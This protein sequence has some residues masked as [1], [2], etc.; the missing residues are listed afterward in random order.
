MT[1]LRSL[2]LALL[3]AAPVAAQQV[4]P[5]NPLAQPLLDRAGHV[6]EDA[7]IRIPLRPDDGR[8]ATIDGAQLKSILME[9]D[10]ISVA[11]RDRGT[12]FWGRNVGT[13]GHV[14]TEDWVAR[15]FRAAG[16]QD[17]HKQDFPLNPQWRLSGW[18]ITF[19]ARG[20]TFGLASARPPERAA[21]TPEGGLEYEL[22]W[23]GQGSEADYIGRDVTGKA[24]LVQDV[25]EPGT[26][27]HTLANED[28]VQRAYEKGAAAVG[29]VFGISDNFAVW[30][31]T[32]DGPGFN[33]GYEDGMRLRDLLGQG[34]RVTV[35]L[36]VDSEMVPDLTAASVWGTLPGQTDEEILI[37]AH[38]DGYFEA[39]LDNASGLAVMMGLLDH[40]S[41]LP[42]SQRPRTIRFLGSVGHHSGP[43]T[44]WL[45]DHA[46]TDL[47]NT[48]LAI[49]LEHVAVVRTQ[50][51]GPRLRQ[52]DAVSPMRWWLYASPAVLDV[53]RDAF[54]R[55]NV[56]ITADMDPGASGEMGRMARDIPSLQVITSPEIKH[57]EQDTPDWVPAVGLEQIARAYAKIIDGVN[58]LDRSQIQPAAAQ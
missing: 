23:V 41:S 49:N 34:E 11:D 15:R 28:V 25:P 16:L 32:G 51:W 56:G 7:Y 3:L 27:N 54:E 47:A 58:E 12:L 17:V 48:A 6:R 1:T 38:M 24:V 33:V 13:Q 8:Y 22:V 45:H 39:A 37:I 43:G 44:T 2:V 53:V 18:N 20:R 40:Y 10:S 42:L 26:I 36:V 52:T 9:V 46:E 21:R 5:A 14:D 50:Y 55:F 35:K 57:T 29:I 19:N 4:A 31:R 30:Q